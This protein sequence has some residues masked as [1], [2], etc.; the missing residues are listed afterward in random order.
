MGEGGQGKV[1]E[2]LIDNNRKRCW[3]VHVHKC[4]NHQEKGPE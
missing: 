1:E 3:I 4:W 2:K